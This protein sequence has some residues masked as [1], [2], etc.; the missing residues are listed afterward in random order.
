[1]SVFE[2]FTAEARQVLI[3]AQ[4][5]ALSLGHGR[6]GTEH[7]LLGLLAKSDGV[8]AA[9][10]G[11]SGSEAEEVRAAV[12]RIVGRGPPRHDDAAALRTIGI[13]LDVVRATVEESFGPGALDR[14]RRPAS[15]VRQR[16]CWGRPGH[17]AFTPRSKKALDLAL[18]EAL[19]LRHDHIG[20][21][22]VLLG[23]LA[24][25][26]GLGCKILVEGGVRLQELRR[27]TLVALGE[28]A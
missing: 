18:R 17:P 21:E 6:I 26:E 8:A 19:E 27:R 2:R 5:E 22:H 16:R 10:L 25:G 4:Q 1:M 13:D 23:L 14:P 7:L 12:E 9:V 28:A 24:E 20:T 11:G 3:L 15:R